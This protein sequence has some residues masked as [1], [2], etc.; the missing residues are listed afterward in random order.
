MATQFQAISSHTS[1]QAAQ[2]FR[3]RAAAIRLRVAEKIADAIVDGSPVDTGTYIMAHV[4]GTGS[5]DEDGS[6][7]SH[8][9]PRG[10]DRSQ[11]TNLA[12]GNLRRS[13][14]AAAVQASSEIWFRNRAWHAPAVEHLGWAA[15]TQPYQVYAR[16][17]A[18]VPTFIR[19]AAREYSMEVRG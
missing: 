16:A 14:S 6:R 7:S 3:E 5:S 11:F 8:G 12:R 1:Q 17:R 10:R 2:I 19:E 13:V 18:Q 4:A 9:K 15:G